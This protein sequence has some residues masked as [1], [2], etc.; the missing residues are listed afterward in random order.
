MDCVLKKRNTACM[1]ML[2][3]RRGLIVSPETIYLACD[4]YNTQTGECAIF[5]QEFDK[6]FK[7]QFMPC[8]YNA[9]DEYTEEDEDYSL[10][11]PD[12]EH[13]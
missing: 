1:C 11:P 13:Y 10:Y 9:E 8:E 4:L 7:R 12:D 3:S 2:I 6:E 5:T